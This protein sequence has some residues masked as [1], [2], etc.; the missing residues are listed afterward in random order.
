M[1]YNHESICL[2]LNYRFVVRS[3]LYHFI[4][5]SL[6]CSFSFSL[7]PLA[8]SRRL[9]SQQKVHLLS[10]YLA[11]QANFLPQHYSTTENAHHVPTPQ[12]ACFPCVDNQT[13]EEIC[14]LEA[15]VGAYTVCDRFT[16]ND[17]PS[18]PFRCRRG[19]PAYGFPPN[20]IL[21]EVSKSS[22]EILFLLRLDKLFPSCNIPFL[23]LFCGGFT[24]RK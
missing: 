14:H 15:R 5:P 10:D 1:D 24:S 3:A 19:C 2:N 13:E 9:P 7:T 22:K 8:M 6:N 18:Y 16:G 12:K 20:I 23:P 17:Y 21:K 4:V 11:R